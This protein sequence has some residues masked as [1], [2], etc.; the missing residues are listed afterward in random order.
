M[1]TYVVNTPVPNNVVTSQTP[2]VTISGTAPIGTVEVLWEN[3][4]YGEEGTAS[5]TETW[6]VE[7][8]PLN[9]WMNTVDIT[10]VDTEGGTTTERLTI[11]YLPNYSRLS[12][13]YSSKGRRGLAK[14][15]YVRPTVGQLFTS[16]KYVKTLK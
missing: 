15:G 14:Q 9:N 6:I 8:M 7:D 12:S 16:K 3:I 4:T 10:A 5:G 2:T 1:I 11:Q 13:I